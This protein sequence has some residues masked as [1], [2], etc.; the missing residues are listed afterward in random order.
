MRLSRRRLLK[1]ALCGAFV[2][3]AGCFDAAVIVLCAAAGFSYR[4]WLA[5][6]AYQH[7]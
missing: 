2:G 3:A 5:W 4:A 7:A 1:G 6:Q